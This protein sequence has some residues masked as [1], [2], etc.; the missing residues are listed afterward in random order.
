LIG[1]V[2]VALSAFLAAI[3]VSKLYWGY[4]LRRPGLDRRMLQ[5]ERVHSL[6]AVRSERGPDGTVGLVPDRPHLVYEHL[7]AC[8]GDRP[9]QAY[10]CLGGRVLV[11]LA[12]K[13]M[14]PAASERLSP[15]ELDLLYDRLEGTGKLVEGAPGY[16]HA[17]ELAG[18]VLEAEGRGGRRY[19]FVA[20]RGR[21]VSNDHYPY[22]EF[23]FRASERG[24]DP[25][26]LSYRRFYYDVAGIEGVEWPVA[27]A[28]L[29]LLGALL[30]ALILTV[31]AAIDTYRGRDAL[32]TVTA[33]MVLVLSVAVT[34]AL[35]L[36][37][38]QVQGTGP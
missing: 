12:G 3:G 37:G 36:G 32:P 17:K 33:V 18:L 29:L 5:I 19:L 38:C 13:G 7:D 9:S 1:M 34:L 24:A 35:G 16:D 2:L 23:L 26:L 15:E 31:W 20:A 25:R 8:R 10:Y 4:F 30:L 21:Q 6:T 11:A 14:L 22:Y 27:F 28:A